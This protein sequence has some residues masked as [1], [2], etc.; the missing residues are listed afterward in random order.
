MADVKISALTSGNPAQSGDEIPIARS[1]ANYKVTAGSIAALGGGGGTTTNALT[2][3]NSGSGAASGTTFN[4]SAAQTI[5][6]NTIGAPSITGTNAT[7]TW[8]IDVTGSAG[9]A[10]AVSGGGA[11]RL[12]YQT[13]SSTTSFVTAPTV[14]DTFLKWNGSAFVWDAASGAGTVTSITAGSGLS[15]GTIT[16]SGTIALAT[17]YGDTVNPYA[18]KTA[19]Y[20]LASPNGSSGVPTFRALVAADIPQ[21]SLATGVTGNLPV[22]NL[23]SGTGASATTYWRGDGTWA[24]PAG[25]GTVTSVDLSMPSGF[26][27]AGSPVTSSGT[28]AVT[29]TLSGV[30]KGTGSGFTAATAGTDYQAPITLTTTGTSGAATFVGNTLNIPQY[31]GGGGSGTVTSVAQSFTGGIVSVAGSP[32]T[33]SGTL[34]LTVAG[35]SGGIPYFSSGTTWASSGVLAANALMV[36]GGAGVAPSTITTGTGVISALALATNAAG[37][38][39]VSGG[40]LGTPSSGTVTNLTGTAS[41]NINGTVGATTPTTGAFTTLSAS[42]TTTLSGL[43]AS[44]ALALDASKNIVSVTN[45]GSGNNVLATSPTLTTPNLGTPSAVTLTNATGLPLSTGVTGNLPVTN[46]NSGTGATSSTFWRGDGTW[47]TPAGGGG[48][49]GG[50]DTQIQFNSSG[51][52]GG[53]ANFTWDGTNVQIGATGALRFADTD[54]SNYVAFKSPGTVS[55]NVT[56]TLPSADGTSNQ[57][58]TTNG[59]GTLSWSSPAGSGTVTSVGLSMPTGFSVSGSPVTGSGTLA[60]TTTL[61][62]ILKGNGSGF[63]TATASTDYAPATTGTNAQLLANNGSGGFSNVTVGSNLTLSAGTLSATGGL[64]W[65]SVQT[66]G[67]TAVAGRAYPCNTTSAAFTVTL[68]A[69]PIAGD[70]VQLLDYAGTFSQNWLTINPNGNN[71]NGNS[72]F[73]ALTS[74]NA[75]AQFVYVDATRGWSLIAGAN[76]TISTADQYFSSVSLL[77]SGNGTNNLANSAFLDSSSNALVITRNGNTTQGSFAP[78]PKSKSWFSGYFDGSGDYLSVAHNA[79]LNLGSNDWC[80]EFWVYKTNSTDSVLVTK[81]PNNGTAAYPNIYAQNATQ[82]IGIE[83]GGATILTTSSITLNAWNHIAVVKSGTSSNNVK[84]Y[85]NGV[86]DATTA[87]LSSA[88]TSNTNPLILGGDT[89]ANYLTGYMASCRVTNGSPVYLNNFTPSKTPLTSTGDTAFLC[90][91]ANCGIFDSSSIN[92]FESLGDAKITTSQW[93]WGGSSMVFDGTGDYLVFPSKTQLDF[94]TGDFTIEAWIKPT[95]IASDTFVVSSVG[96]G[97]MFFGFQA[98]AGIGYGRTGVAWDYVSTTLPTVSTWQHVAVSRSGTSIRLF[99]NG[100]QIGTTQ[101]S[102]QAYNLAV[103]TA[104][105]GSMGASLYFTGY[106]QDIRVTKGVARYTSNFTAP[107]EAFPIY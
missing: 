99:L 71:I 104:S 47:A 55:A 37:G 78:N 20:V 76:S 16:T 39:V 97:G 77:L 41:I 18:S 13:G 36:G 68:P 54:S 26:S 96:G 38:L 10:A 27:V 33:T 100:T 32:I 98:G 40:A 80:I 19:N 42:S 93:R 87:T 105:V 61:N 34:A 63:T 30:L 57:V 58:L 106:M 94:S 65:Q 83:L 6:Y 79:V 17:A 23:N 73:V 28:L 107:T 45:T 43:T 60:V 86:A 48:T 53:S 2:M 102:S 11:N 7:G 75:S 29:T 22:T 35:T 46:L 92:N 3:D 31:S 8:P 69:S 90:N 82:K 4:G 62:G 72:N 9:T 74:N 5:S 50:S 1:G 85:I 95:S 24:T 52:F 67:F 15:G 25:A 49:P 64:A 12:V 101:T 44:T 56:W 14:T 70:Q 88:I 51:S 81:R 59:S 21:I 91:F 89:N 84:C 103:T 66:T